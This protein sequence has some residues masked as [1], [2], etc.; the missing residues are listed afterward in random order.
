MPFFPGK[1]T[2]MPY[3]FGYKIMPFLTHNIKNDYV[4]FGWRV[5]I[6]GSKKKKNV[7]MRCVHRKLHCRGHP[8][9]TT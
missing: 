6:H 2:I 8:L 4:N 7:L 5:K 1:K 9:F 3:F